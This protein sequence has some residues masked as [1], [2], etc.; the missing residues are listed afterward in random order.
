[1]QVVS[2]G[3]ADMSHDDQGQAG[4]ER[5][6]PLRCKGGKPQARSPEESA[7]GFHSGAT[8]PSP[9][10]R[11]DGDHHRAHRSVTTTGFSQAKTTFVRIDCTTCSP[12]NPAV[13]ES[14]PAHIWEEDQ[15][16]LYRT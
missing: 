2:R 15:G 10:G 5:K 9:P 8:R 16:I 13:V 11:Q 7:K 4:T 6:F 3:S 12:S 1:M 14:L